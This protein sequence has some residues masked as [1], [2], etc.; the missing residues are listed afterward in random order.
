VKPATADQPFVFQSVASA[1]GD[2]DARARRSGTPDLLVRQTEREIGEIVR[3]V[4]GAS[5]SGRTESQY[6]M[7]L[8]D[9][10]LRV[11]AAEGVVIWHQTSPH[12]F[13]VVARLGRCTDQTLPPNSINAHRRL[14]QEIADGAGPSV[15][16]STPGATDP[17]IPANPSEFPAALVGV[18]VVPTTGPEGEAEEDSADYLIEVFLEPGGGTTAQRGYLRFVAQM[19]DLAGEFLRNRLMQTLRRDA[20]L[21]SQIDRFAERIRPLTDPRSIAEAVT[22]FTAETFPFAR[23]ALVENGA[24]PRVVAVSHV[25]QI[26]HQS[27]GVKWLIRASEDGADAT[28]SEQPVEDSDDDLRLE[29]LEPIDDAESYKLL[30]LVRQSDEAIDDGLRTQVTRVA[31]VAGQAMGVARWQAGPF[32]LGRLRVGSGASMSQTGRAKTRR[33]IAIIGTILLLIVAFLPV[34]MTV[35]SSAVLRP[36][37]WQAVCAPRNAVV[38]AVHV[39]HQQFVRR[40]DPL[41][42]LE[43]SQLQHQITSLQGDQLRLQAELA[44][45]TENLIRLDGRENQERSHTNSLRR[46]S[47]LR[48]E[49]IAKQIEHLRLVQASLRI[50]ARHDGY[51]DSWELRDRLSER[52]VRFGEPLM[53]VIRKDSSWFVEAEVPQHRL[54]GIRRARA[55]QSLGVTVSPTAAREQRWEAAVERIGPTIVR[56]EATETTLVSLSIPSDVQRFSSE[57]FHEGMPLRVLFRCDRAPLAYVLT[58]D[59][60]NAVRDFV[61]LHLGNHQTLEQ[62][63]TP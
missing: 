19:A 44:A 13:R 6:W 23:V 58:Q 63:M 49:G 54:A 55:A 41:I 39:A 2:G 62:E 37:D 3:E 31:K 26:D 53:K 25:E 20:S 21:T 56:D 24:P 15:V 48:L 32:G 57:S 18:V 1:G 36:R 28:V 33:R 59:A 40:G 14:L 9:R 43:D 35:T 22:D 52:P 5:R 29:V 61:G 34:R 4:A 8:T 46:V 50:T 47:E 11:M 27:A 60:V 38:A 45:Q 30:G 17:D 51:V 42:T 7:F 12:D 10:I 16:P